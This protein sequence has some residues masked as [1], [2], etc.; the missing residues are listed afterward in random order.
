LTALH[1]EGSAI[2][3]NRLIVK[4]DVYAW[5]QKGR[6]LL[7]RCFGSNSKIIADFEFAVANSWPE[8]DTSG[9]W[10]AVNEKTLTFQLRLLG[11]CV[12][13]LQVGQPP[14]QSIHSSDLGHGNSIFLVHGHNEAVRDKVAQ[15]LEQ[16]DLK[17]VILE[18]QTDKGARS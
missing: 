13:L 12:D 5:T 2:L 15:F 7:L 1:K 10:D 6:E 17:L 18:E 3:S 8:N 4:E 16:L 11:N 14:V 9:A